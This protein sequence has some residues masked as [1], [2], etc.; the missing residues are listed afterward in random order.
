MKELLPRLA[1]PLPPAGETLEPTAL[2][3]RPPSAIW[4][5][6]GFGGGEH[7]AAQAAAHPGIGFIGCEP[8]VNGVAALLARIERDDLDM[9]RVHADDARP[10]IEALPDAAIGRVF[11]LFPD[12]WPKRRQQKRR[13]I[14]DDILDQLARIMVDGA[15]LRLATDDP[16]Y[17]AWM[18]E[19]LMR[20]AAFAWLA[21]GPEDW[22][23][24]PPDWPPTRYEE[25]ARAQGRCCTYLRFRRRPRDA[26]QEA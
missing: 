20:H 15:E 6:I 4:L 1:V 23:E 5:E 2:F 24:R 21:E 3:S 8:F 13:I 12:P 25:K 14:Q 17:L 19:R 9:I 10:L 7:L 11:V 26:P 22:R 18:L 16:G